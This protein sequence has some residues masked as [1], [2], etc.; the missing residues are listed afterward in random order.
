MQTGKFLNPRSIQR[1]FENTFAILQNMCVFKEA[2]AKGLHG[3]WGGR[4]RNPYKCS[5][6]KAHLSWRS[7]TWVCLSLLVEQPLL[8]KCSIKR[9]SSG[10]L[11]SW[12]MSKI[13]FI[14]E[15]CAKCAK[16]G[17][18]VKLQKFLEGFYENP[19]NVNYL[20]LASICSWHLL[21]VPSIIL[22]VWQEWSRQLHTKLS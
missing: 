4:G 11:W 13:K 20:R 7:N 9:T 18:L 5:M 15:K 12:S 10:L 3:G 21:F 2:G 22:W 6:Y 8:G 14:T 16:H 1:N 17:V 19:W